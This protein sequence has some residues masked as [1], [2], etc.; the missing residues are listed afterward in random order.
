MFLKNGG[1]PY[2]LQYLLGH[3]DMSTVREYAKITAQDAKEMYRSPLDA[4]EQGGM[5]AYMAEYER[6][7]CLAIL[8][9]Y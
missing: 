5:D 9:G 1:D 2:T 4:L 7:A 6:A 8:S 3:E